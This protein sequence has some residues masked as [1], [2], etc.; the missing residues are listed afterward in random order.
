MGQLRISALSLLSSNYF[1]NVKEKE[2]I[3]IKNPLFK[4]FNK[5]L[6]I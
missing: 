6:F 1:F 3:L 4:I 2:R 5:I